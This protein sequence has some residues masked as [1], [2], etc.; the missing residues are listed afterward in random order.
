[1]AAERLSNGRLVATAKRQASLQLGTLGGGNHFV[2]LQADEEDRL[3]LMV[4]SG[5]RGMGQAIR[6]HHME[7]AS[8]A[9]AGLR[10]LEATSPAGAAYLNDVEWARRYAEANRSAI[11][12]AVE[13]AVFCPARWATAIS[14]DHNHVALED[15]GGCALWVHRKG[16]MMAAAGVPGVLPG[17]MGTHS[18]H[19]EGRGVAEALRSSAHGAGRAMSRDRARRAITSRELGRQMAG[20]WY[21]FRLAEALREEAPRAYKDVRSV[22]RAQAELVKVIRRLRPILN[23]KST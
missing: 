12:R 13:E 20:V 3:W 17:S 4:H 15:H 22:L 18:Y 5:S 6:T 21:D 10:V 19:V 8:P 14:A 7:R 1:L 11:A 16:A 23:H 9:A 2:E